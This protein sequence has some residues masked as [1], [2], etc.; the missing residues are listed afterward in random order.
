MWLALLRSMKMNTAQLKNIAKEITRNPLWGMLVLREYVDPGHPLFA[1][2]AAKARAQL[3]DQPDS[4][5]LNRIAGDI[6]NG[7]FTGS[8]DAARSAL[9]PGAVEKKPG[10]GRSLALP[11][12]SKQRTHSVRRRGSECGFDSVFKKIRPGAG[13]AQ[14]NHSDG[15]PRRRRSFSILS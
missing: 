13:F 14:Y 10:T 12:S 2:C 9:R 15:K 3:S 4:L 8:L 1:A 7:T 6:L 11:P 5:P